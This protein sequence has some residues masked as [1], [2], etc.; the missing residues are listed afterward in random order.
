MSIYDLLVQISKRKDEKVCGMGEKGWEYEGERKTDGRE[1]RDII[2]IYYL[3][4]ERE[5]KKKKE[6]TKDN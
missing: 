4:R 2:C 5:G 1:A 3:E 6:K